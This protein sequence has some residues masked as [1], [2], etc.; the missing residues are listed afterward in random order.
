MTRP[1]DLEGTTIGRYQLER[2][3]G[4]GTTADVYLALDRKLERHVAIK[5]MRPHVVDDPRRI[6]RVM[7]E[8][9]IHARLEHVNIV[10]IYDLVHEGEH[11]LLVMRYAQGASLEATRQQ[12]GGRLTLERALRYGGEVLRGVGF[13]HDRGVVHRDLKPQN[14]QITEADEALV[15]DFGIA[16]LTT[17]GSEAREGQ[18]EGGIAGSPAYMAP[19]QA[20][21]QYTDART[22]IYALG[23]VLFQLIT[24]HH[25]F[26]GARSVVEMIAAQVQRP[27][28][29]P[30]EILSTIPGP[31]EEALLRALAK[32]P[33]ERFRSCDEFARALGLELTT[34]PRHTE[35]QRWDPRVVYR[36]PVRLTVAG[37]ADVDGHIADV[38][39]GGL[40]ISAPVTLTSGDEVEL[41]WKLPTQGPHRPI[42]CR[43][44]VTWVK[45]LTGE[46]GCRAGLRFTDISDADRRHVAEFIRNVLV[47]QTLPG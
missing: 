43:G 21:G 14:I 12:A 30:R 47:L 7:T 28:P 17:D 4:R 22:D 39:A 23:L 46:R 45:P 10:R 35:E 8:A 15:M 40:A 13:A 5:A 24:G 42:R 3:I 32:H 9:R 6:E 33:S 31:I 26:A 29:S 11:L 38:S 41:R 27:P 34:R 25:P 19:E 18:D 1:T 16:R 44:R 20:R 36:A 2:C 37:R